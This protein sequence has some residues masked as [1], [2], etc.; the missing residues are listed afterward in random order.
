MPPKQK[1]RSCTEQPSTGLNPRE[2]SRLTDERLQ[3]IIPNIVNEIHQRNNE[4]GS[5]G[6]RTR[7]R[8]GHTGGRSGRTVGRGGRTRGDGSSG[9]GDDS[10]EHDDRENPHNN[11]FT[12]QGCNYKYFSSC[13][14]PSFSGK[15]GATGLMRWIEGMERKLKLTRCLDKHKVHYATSTLTG[16]AQTWWDTQE[17]TLGTIVIDAMQW[18]DVKVRILAQYCP[19]NELENLQEEFWHLKMVGF[20]IQEH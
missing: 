13:N 19:E 18:N 15:E 2:L 6:G 1:T 14:P 4:D 11:D 5:S 8:G 20:D 10:L 12:N 3:N 7:G 16:Q 17:R 9:G